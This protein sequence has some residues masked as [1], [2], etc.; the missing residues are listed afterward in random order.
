MHGQVF[1][2][3]PPLY[4]LVL[5]ININTSYGADDKVENQTCAPGP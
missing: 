5:S 3:M 4:Y 1:S 2:Q